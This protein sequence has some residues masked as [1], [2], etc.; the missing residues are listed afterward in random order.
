MVK[1]NREKARNYFWFTT[2]LLSLFALNSCG[3]DDG[4][5]FVSDRVQVEATI[6]EGQDVNA[7]G[8]WNQAQLVWQDE[9]DG[10]ELSTDKWLLETTNKVGDYQGWQKYTLTDNLEISKGTLKITA[11]KVGEGQ[12]FGDYTSARLNSTFAFKYGRL[13]MRAKMPDHKGSGLWAKL[14]MLGD[15]INAVGYPTCGMLGILEY[16]SHAPNSTFVT[17]H[18]TEFRPDNNPSANSGF[19]PLETVDEEFHNY[20]VLWTDKYVKFYLDYI[21]NVI[22]TYNKPS[23]ATDQNWPFAKSQYFVMDI[24]VGNEFTNSNGVD[25]TIFPAVMEIDYVRVYH[26][27]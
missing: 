25:D 9:F 20:G 16:V 18:S 11:K 21:D 1:E 17:V 6:A 10:N 13:E 3:S 19:K 12:K 22:Y 8:F 5:G 15:N 27:N 24:V 14:F 2:V 4:Q 23:M 26:P 7:Q